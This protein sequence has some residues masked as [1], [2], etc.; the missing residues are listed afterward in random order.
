MD[1]K[2]KT[3][4]LL[5][6]QDVMWLPKA[7]SPCWTTVTLA[8]AWTPLVE[9]KS[10]QQQWWSVTTIITRWSWTTTARPVTSHHHSSVVGVAHHPWGPATA[11]HHRWVLQW[12]PIATTTT[13]K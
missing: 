3:S 2:V 11:L 13:D 12:G 7:M 5:P 8:L 6:L 10:H 4:K 1:T 9:L